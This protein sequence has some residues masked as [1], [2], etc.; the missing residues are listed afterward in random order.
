MRLEQSVLTP[1]GKDPESRRPSD[2][3]VEPDDTG[4]NLSYRS[5]TTVRDRLSEFRDIARRPAEA[6][7]WV[8]G[9]DAR[10]TRNSTRS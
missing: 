1:Y 8:C 5:S 4:L 9:T 3:R 7:R 2:L 6:L 10:D